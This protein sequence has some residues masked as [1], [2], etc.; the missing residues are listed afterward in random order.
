[1]ARGT[2]LSEVSCTSEN[3]PPTSI[4][5]LS[6]II[7]ILGRGERV[8]SAGGVVY[9]LQQSG[10]QK[11]IFGSFMVLHLVLRQGH[12]TAMCQ[13]G[14]PVNVYGFSHLHLP[15]DQR[16]LGFQ[17]HVLLCLAFMW[18]VDVFT[19]FFMFKFLFLTKTT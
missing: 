5:K 17:A 1:M 12:I 7:S 13:T 18:V 9:G 16:V 8:H 15:S 3:S 19:C 11:S 14:G 10:G 2:R 6:K 4:M